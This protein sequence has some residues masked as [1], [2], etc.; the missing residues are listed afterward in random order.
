MVDLVPIPFGVL[1]T[2]L[3]RE[4]DRKRSA[5]DLPVQRFVQ[6]D[7]RRDLSVLCH[8]RR[9]STPL[10]PAAG[11]HTQMAQNIVLS[12]LAGGR[13][14]EFKTVQIKDDLRVP[15]PCIDV[16]TVGFNVEWSQELT[17]DQ[18]REEYV[19]AAMLIEM[20]KASG[21]VRD[22]GDT[23]F[24]MSIGYDLAGIRSDKMHAFM[25]GLLDATPVVEKLRAQI[26]EAWKDF[27]DLSYPRRLST[28]LTLST[29]HG[30]P[31]D[32]IERIAA[33]LLE[34]IGL[35]VVIKLNPT[36]LGAKRPG[37]FLM[38][39]SAIPNSRCPTRPSSRMR[40]GNKWSISLGGSTSAHAGFA[41]DLE[42]NFPT[43]WSCAITRRFFPQANSRCISPGHRCTRWRW[44][45][46]AVSDRRSPI[47]SRSPSRPASTMRILP[48][49]WV[50]GWRRSRSAPT[51]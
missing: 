9:A 29:F 28:T 42:S 22:L 17:L 24:D 14:I 34:E 11:P 6:G 33:F 49:P 32:E 5:F 16:Q 39:S 31:P 38:I 50:S 10:G 18:S 15:R 40:A 1:I 47:A 20:L 45:S 44:L 51:F 13:I 4:L 36:L 35:D 26:P 30:C 48:M 46:S 3:F 25:A 41:A 27:R 19:K 43:R 8:G 2:R 7:N 23:V 37:K 12:W 21:V